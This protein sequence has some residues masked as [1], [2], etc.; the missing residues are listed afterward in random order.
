MR[1][2]RTPV[3]QAAELLEGPADLGRV[4]AERLALSAKVSRP[5]LV[6]VALALVGGGVWYWL[7]GQQGGSEQRSRP[8]EPVIGNLLSE[9]YSFESERDNWSGVEGA[10]QAFLRNV[11]AAYSGDYGLSCDLGAQEWARTRSKLVTIGDDKELVAS[12]QL[13]ARGGVRVRLGL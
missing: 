11:A 10:P 1:L 13:R 2:G 4:S 9:D 3:L 7:Q 6:V 8:V 5:G 12:A